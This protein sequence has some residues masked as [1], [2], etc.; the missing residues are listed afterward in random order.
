MII[1][2]PDK[3]GIWSEEIRVGEVGGNMLGFYGGKFGPQGRSVMGH[4]YQGSFHIWSLDKVQQC[5]G[6]V[7]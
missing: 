3:S 1:W 7:I 4:G 5:N 2:A 6:I